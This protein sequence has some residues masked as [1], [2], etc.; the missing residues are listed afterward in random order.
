MSKKVLGL[1][2]GRKMGN[3]D[4]M[5]KEALMECEKA[6]NE[7][8][9][10]RV[11]ELDIRPCTGCIACVIGLVSGRGKGGCPIKDDFHL[12]EEAIME[13]DGLIIASPTYVLSPTGMFKTVCDRIGPSHD[14][15]FR[16]AAYKEGLQQGKSLDS[17]PD[18]RSFKPR[19]AALISVGGAMTKNW[20]S[21]MLPTMYEITMSMGTNVIDIHE[22]YGAMAFEHVLGN[23]EQM[24][25]MIKL[26]KNISE[27]LQAETEC[28]RI[29]WRGNEEGN[30]PVCHLNMLT[31]NNESTKVECPVCGIE[32][33]LVIENNKIKTVFS[34]E[35]QQRSRLFMEGKWEHSTEIKTRAAHSGQI[36]NLKEL[37]SK[38]VGYAQ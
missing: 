30:C 27:A 21:F 1:S 29:K 36:P 4:V 15:T 33:E 22:Y 20:L 24:E 10:I 37:K 19:V 2:F 17:L 38:Y 7:V 3:C 35:Q 18:V 6:G 26:G 14:I 28:D 16:E 8:K 34:I 31:V 13:A 23:K 11:D 9:F 25:R 12:L 32:G 5:V